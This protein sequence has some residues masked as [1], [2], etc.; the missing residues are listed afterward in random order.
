M[1]AVPANKVDV[2]HSGHEGFPRHCDLVLGF[3]S[4]RERR[5]RENRAG[6]S[7]ST[8][9]I[10]IEITLASVK[11]LKNREAHSAECL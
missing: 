4:R 2:R 8:L 9:P 3:I 10:Y 11:G 7:F 5:Y 1:F 6:S